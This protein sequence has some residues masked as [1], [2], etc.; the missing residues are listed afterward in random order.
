METRLR[1]TRVLERL[2]LSKLGE[3][4]A[5]MVDS[6]VDVCGEG[7]TSSSVLASNALKKGS[8]SALLRFRPMDDGDE[9][10]IDD[11]DSPAPP[12]DRTLDPLP[13]SYTSVSSL[14]CVW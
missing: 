11:N 12:I 6:K 5:S 2:F 14:L 9:D 3:T 13:I 7:T 4:S 10:G 1:G 8:S